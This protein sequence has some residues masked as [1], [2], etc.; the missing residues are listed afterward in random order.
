[1]SLTP[2]YEAIKCKTSEKPLLRK[3]T[4]E[5]LGIGQKC[6]DGLLPSVKRNAFERVRRCI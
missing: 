2:T 3:K 4:A 5:F 6:K 1:M